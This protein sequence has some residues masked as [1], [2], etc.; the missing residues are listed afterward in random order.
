MNS[1]LT[2]AQGASLGTAL[3]R[4]ESIERIAGQYAGRG[5]DEQFRLYVNLKADTRDDAG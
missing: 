5:G 3:D 1:H 2:D 4:V